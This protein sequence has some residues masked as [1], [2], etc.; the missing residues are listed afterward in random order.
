M[1]A[2]QSGDACKGAARSFDHGRHRRAGQS[3]GSRVRQPRLGCVLT[4]V[5]SRSRRWLGLRNAYGVR[6]SRSLRPDGSLPA[7]HARAEK[8]ALRF[9][10]WSTWRAWT[11]K[12][13]YERSGSQ[14]RNIIT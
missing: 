6:A 1:N 12:G 8:E 10:R 3:N 11:T 5:S 7:P 13:F 2:I 4:D 9:R 14:I